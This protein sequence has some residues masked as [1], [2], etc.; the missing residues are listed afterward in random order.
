MWEGFALFGADGR[1]DGLLSGQPVRLQVWNGQF[2]VANGGGGSSLRADRWQAAEWETF[3]LDRR[4]GSGEL[5]HGDSISL[6]SANGSYVSA[7][8]GGGELV[9]DRTTAAEWEHF[10]LERWPVTLIHLRAASRQYVVAEGGGTGAVLADRWTP[11]LWETF[12]LV[13]KEG[14]PEGVH[15]GDRVSL[16]AWKE[17]IL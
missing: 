3:V 13:N 10:T 8:R 4:D 16:Q 11:G 12:A 17:L 7:E 14:R 5:G 9:A 2:V 6:R 1:D 15:S